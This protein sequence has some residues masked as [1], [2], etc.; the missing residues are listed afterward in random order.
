M[1]FVFCI[2]VNGASDN[3]RSLLPFAVISRSIVLDRVLFFGLV[4]AAHPRESK[5]ENE[6]YGKEEIRN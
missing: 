5:I 4:A 6:G 3:P 2:I 1:L